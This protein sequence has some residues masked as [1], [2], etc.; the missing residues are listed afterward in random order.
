TGFQYLRRYRESGVDGLQDRSRRPH[1]SPRRTPA[2]MEARIDA[3]RRPGHQDGEPGQRIG[4]AFHQQAKSSA[5]TVVPR[6]Q[7]VTVPYT[8]PYW[9]RRLGPGTGTGNE[10]R[11][12]SRHDATLAQFVHIMDKLPRTMQDKNKMSRV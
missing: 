10:A 6:D 5:Q 2:A 3:G 9:R 7:T 4:Q 11:I 12:L 1:T 8:V